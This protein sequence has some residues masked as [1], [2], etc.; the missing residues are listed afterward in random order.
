MTKRRNSGR[1]KVPHDQRETGRRRWESREKG[2]ANREQQDR[3][4]LL[5]QVE[6]WNN[7]ELGEDG[8]ERNREGTDDRVEVSMG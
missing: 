5:Y 6:S 4:A 8:N 1:R 7:G 3:E 2:L